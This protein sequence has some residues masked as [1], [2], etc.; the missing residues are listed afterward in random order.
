MATAYQDRIF[1]SP[2]PNIGD[3][4]YFEAAR[5][6]KLAIKYCGDCNRYH[7]YPRALCP[8][9]HSPKTE[10][11]HSVGRGT[12]YTYSITR[13]SGP[14]P[15]AIAYVTLDEGPSMMTNIVD[16][17]LDSIRIGQRVC[18]TFKSSDGGVDVPMFRPE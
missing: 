8:F 17:D 14:V 2:S 10:W 3:E 6:G 11:R 9:C 12:I 13:Q 1:S 16:C 15:Y 5:Q 18:V 4:P 7:H